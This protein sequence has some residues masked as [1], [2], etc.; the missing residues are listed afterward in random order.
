MH[1]LAFN[2]LLDEVGPEATFGSFVRILRQELRDIHPG[3]IDVYYYPERFSKG[4]SI[5]SKNW[6]FLVDRVVR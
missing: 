4:Y 2:L 1:K 3:F 6:T 5:V